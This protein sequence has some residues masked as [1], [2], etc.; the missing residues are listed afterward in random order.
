MPYPEFFVAPMRDELVSLG[1]QELRTP[2]EV[3]AF[4]PNRQS[5]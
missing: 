1:V 5:A 4:Q 2:G 3:A